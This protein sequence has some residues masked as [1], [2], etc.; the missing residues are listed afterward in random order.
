MVKDLVGR[1]GED[2]DLPEGAS[3]ASV[4]E[5][6]AERYPRLQ[7]MA[8]SIVLARNQEFADRSTPLSEGDEVAFLPPVSG[9]S[10][11]AAAP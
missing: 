4:F 10:G 11:A 2:S 1:T 3:L 5:Q 8:R 7:E 9:G 6:Y